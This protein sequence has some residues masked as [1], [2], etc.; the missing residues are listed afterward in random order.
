M[1]PHLVYFLLLGAFLF[2]VGLMLVL[3]KRNAVIMLIGI[4]FMFNAANINLVAFSQYE[5]TRLQGQVF[6][7]FVIVVAAAETVVALAILIQVYK[8][9]KTINLSVINEIHK[10]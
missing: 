6:S 3:T 9:F 1:L 8:H 10:R 7:L 5:P 4:E 2:C